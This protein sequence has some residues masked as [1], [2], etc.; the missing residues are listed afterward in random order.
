MRDLI[1]VHGEPSREVYLDSENS[2]LIFPKA[3]EQ[4]VRTY[5]EVGY[6]NPSITHK[7]GWESYEVLYKS[8]ELLSQILNTKTGELAYTHGATEANNLAI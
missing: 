3:L 6:G 8:T 5:K 1:A 4:M 2:G 7:I